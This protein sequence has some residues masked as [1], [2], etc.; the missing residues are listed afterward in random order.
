M[1]HMQIQKEKHSLEQMAIIEQSN[2][3]KA[4][5]GPEKDRR[6][7][8]LLVNSLKGMHASEEGLTAKLTQQDGQM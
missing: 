2:L 1:L 8:D 7:A 6:A 4:G 5:V 3:D